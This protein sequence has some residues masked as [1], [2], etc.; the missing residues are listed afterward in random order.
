MRNP[1][2]LSLGMIFLLTM[3]GCANVN[4]EATDESVPPHEQTFRKEME[5]RSPDYRGPSVLEL[6]EPEYPADLAGQGLDGIVM[7]RVLVSYDGQVL[8]SEVQQ[9]LQ[10]ALDQA[11]LEAARGGKYTPATEAGV[12]TEGWLTVPFRYPPPPEEAK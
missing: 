7:I 3:T 9:G 5:G 2:I 11:A 12:A 1:G 10:P 4:V 6:P 8:E